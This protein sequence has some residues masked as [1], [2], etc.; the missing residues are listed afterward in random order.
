[1][2]KM[3]EGLKDEKFEILGFPSNQY[4]GQE[5]WP[6]AKV[7]SETKRLYGR[8]FP[9]FAKSDVFG[10]NQNPVYK[11]LFKAFPGD[12]T[13]NFASKFIVDKN[14]NC[15][16]RFDKGA[17]WEEIEAEIRRQL[18]VGIDLVMPSSPSSLKPSA[19]DAEEF[20]IADSS[21]AFEEKKEDAGTTL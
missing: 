7:D 15:V 16:K 18:K 1:M 11:T 6:N 17:S 8:N 20:K 9:L 10:K 2:A 13:W 19:N 4:G 12:I 5:P 3:K 21:A 14:G